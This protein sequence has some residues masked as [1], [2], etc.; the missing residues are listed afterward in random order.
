VWISFAIMVAA[1]TWMLQAWVPARWALGGGIAAALWMIGRHAFDGYWASTFWGG[2]M[3]AIGGALV[4]G[5]V[6]RLARA[7]TVGAS[8]ATGMGLSVLAN[9]RPF[10]G[11]FFV[12]VPMLVVGWLALAHARHKRW[13][14]A[15]T[16]V[17]PMKVVIAI[18]ATLMLI[19]N[20]AVT[21]SATEFPYQTYFNTY[22]SSPTIWGQQAP[23][24]PEYRVAEL[25]VFY[26]EGAGAIAPPARWRDVPM[27]LWSNSAAAR[28]FYAPIFVLPLILVLPWIMRGFWTR[29]VLAS[30]LCTAIAMSL[31]LYAAM[32]HYIAPAV[33]AIAILFINGARFLRQVHRRGIRHGG[34]VVAMVFAAIVLSAVLQVTTAWLPINRQSWRWERERMQQRLAAEGRHFV[35]VD[36]GPRHHAN[37][38]WVYNGA[39]VDGAPVVWA[40]SLGDASDAEFAQY[41]ADRKGWRLHI[42]RDDGPFELTPYVRE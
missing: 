29:V 8:L 36:Y 33:G 16:I 38:E 41:F 25:K 26:T 1:L 34:T 22:D 14:I 15:V 30:L 23:A 13:R 24:M 21:G 42:D 6:K 32:P 40:R 35:L 31:T 2:S 5:G 20:K 12:L 7:P 17:A 28:A 4:L 11:L 19:Y 3:A 10:E 27:R 9:S 39:D 18:T 37:A